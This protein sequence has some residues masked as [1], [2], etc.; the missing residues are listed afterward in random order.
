[1][2]AHYQKH[3]AWTQSE[4]SC[5]C[6]SKAYF[7]QW[8]VSCRCCCP[9]SG[10]GNRSLLAGVSSALLRW[11]S[12]L[13]WQHVLWFSECISC[14]PSGWSPKQKMHSRSAFNALQLWQV[15]GQS[16]VSLRCAFTLQTLSY[17]AKRLTNVNVAADWKGSGSMI[18]EIELKWLYHK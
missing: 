5:I 7:G 16:R 11:L 8:G 9:H 15:G 14:I 10:C 4:Y 6:L 2:L 13:P 17:C 3:K 18:S 1:M 12:P